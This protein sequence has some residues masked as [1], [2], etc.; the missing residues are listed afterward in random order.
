MKSFIALYVVLAMVVSLLSFAEQYTPPTID[1]ARCRK[2]TA[3]KLWGKYDFTRR[4]KSSGEWKCP[5][6]WE[7]TGCTW[8]M[9]KEFEQKQCRRKKTNVNATK[10]PRSEGTKALI[11]AV[12]ALN[13]KIVE[14]GGEPQGSDRFNSA[15]VTDSQLKDRISKLTNQLE[16]M[17]K[18]NQNGAASRAA[19]S[20]ASGQVD[21]APAPPA[22]EDRAEKKRLM[23]NIDAVRKKII[24]LGGT[25]VIKGTGYG[26]NR[27]GKASVEQLQRRLKKLMK[28]NMTLIATGKP[29]VPDI[30]VEAAASGK[31]YYKDADGK[32]KFVGHDKVDWSKYGCNTND[33]GPGEAFEVIKEV[34]QNGR[35]YQKRVK[36]YTGLIGSDSDGLSYF[37]L[38]ECNQGTYQVT[39]SDGKKYAIC[40]AKGTCKNFDTVQ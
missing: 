33:L 27:I 26:I 2:N 28:Q 8:Q 40:A 22:E 25:P 5:N 1:K 18:S 37:D 35:C 21:A 34:D 14:L 39:A 12:R 31:P 11:D 16:L 6:G 29:D 30:P 15:N 36:W 17:R 7:N 38:C 10:G 3:K 32:K 24:E 9:G 4:I 23:A 20:E 19:P 13:N